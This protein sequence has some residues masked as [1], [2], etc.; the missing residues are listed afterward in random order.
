MVIALLLST[1]FWLPLLFLLAACI[2]CTLDV[3]RPC[4]TTFV[5]SSCLLLVTLNLAKELAGDLVIYESLY[6]YFVGRPPTILFSTRELAMESATYR[7][8][9]IG[10]YLPL[11]ALGNI[12][13]GAPAGL[14]IFATLAVYL[15]AQMGI[16]ILGR[17]MRW[18]SRLT[19]TILILTCF[20]SLNFVQTTHLLRQYISASFVFLALCLFI[21][22]RKKA[23]IITAL[24]A[25]TVHNA[26]TLLVAEFS[27]L[28]YLFPFGQRVNILGL[29]WRVP[30]AILGV[31]L[32]VFLLAIYEIAVL[33]TTDPNIS[34]L[35]YLA[36]SVFFVV[37]VISAKLSAADPKIVYYVAIAFALAG[38]ISGTFFFGGFGLVALRY[39]S[40]VEWLAGLM[41][42]IML[43]A[44]PRHRINLY[45]LSR[46][47]VSG[48]ATVI[49]LVRI[50]SATW[51]YGPGGSNIFLLNAYDLSSYLGR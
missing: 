30:A 50:G 40:Y 33:G 38:L 32:S 3:D 36:V 5:V 49:L 42:G 45:L 21:C 2:Y 19:I 47:F 48:L 37:Y 20:A 34:A 9:E 26:T 22:D 7:I 14:S 41:V 23:S 8:S 10:F 13:S 11:W 24:V 31:A 27:L 17:S 43:C 44:I 6:R 18:D 12:F 1:A 16:L 25:C 29:A 15:P 51:S 39:F 4:L 46:W 35:H 28:V